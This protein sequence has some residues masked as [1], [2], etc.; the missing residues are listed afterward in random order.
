MR[1]NAVVVVLG[2]V[3][4]LCVSVQAHPTE[5]P[6]REELLRRIRKYTERDTSSWEAKRQTGNALEEYRRTVQSE[7]TNAPQQIHLAYAGRSQNGESNAMAVVWVTVNQTKNSIVKYGTE[8][9]N[10]S[11]QVT[12]QSSSYLVTWDHVAIMP[13]LQ[14]D[15]R[16]YYMVGDEEAGFSEE[17]TFVTAPKNDPERTTRIITIGNVLLS[18]AV[19]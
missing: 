16:Y 15:T 19:T 1:S 4:A 18:L 12:G 8:S 10:Y 7:G 17:Y 13:N 14:L 2:V 9:G 6:V 5:N 11:H 3:A